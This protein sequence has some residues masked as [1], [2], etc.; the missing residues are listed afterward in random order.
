VLHLGAVRLER[1]RTGKF[2]KIGE[3]YDE[4]RMLLKQL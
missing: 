3:S 4:M 2:S 1:Q